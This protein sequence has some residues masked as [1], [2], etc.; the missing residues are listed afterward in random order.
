MAT[1]KE[2]KLKLIHLVYGMFV[3]AIVIGMSIGSLINQ[4]CTN[5]ETIKTK[6]DMSIFE[7]FQAQQ[8]TQ[9]ERIDK[10]L[11]KIDKKLDV[12]QKKI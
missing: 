6:V 12:I 3:A 5:T 2:A 1:A 4:Q 10:T 11:D 9:F 7:L 8:Y